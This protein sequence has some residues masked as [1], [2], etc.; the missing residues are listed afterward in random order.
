MRRTILFLF[1]VAFASPLLAQPSIRIKARS[2]ADLYAEQRR[3]IG[4]WCR[5]DFEGFRLTG[6]DL[7]RL[8]S[9]S[10]FK[11]NPEFSSVVIVSRFDVQ[12]RD[13]ASWDMDVKYV[14]L[15]RYDRG[16]GY[17]PGAGTDTVTFRT[18]DIDDNIVIADLDPTSPHVSK[19]A[20]VAWM[21][22]ELEKTTSD[23]EKVHLREALKS[24]DPTPT[25]T[26]VPA[27]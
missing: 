22:Q 27:P 19:K 7:A 14:V 24:L 9:L 2:A 10:I 15:G 12:P 6:T 4:S 25:G 26:T 23:V 13:S 18:K 21:R 3:V 20:A 8:R 11:E 16:S 17:V 1:V 5:L